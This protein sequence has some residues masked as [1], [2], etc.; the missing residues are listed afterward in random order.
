MS[1][2]L[3]GLRRF[4]SDSTDGQLTLMLWSEEAHYCRAKGGWH[5]RRPSCHPFARP[6]TDPTGGLRPEPSIGLEI[7]IF[8][9]HFPSR[10]ERVRERKPPK[11][12]PSAHCR[13]APHAHRS[14]S[15]TLLRAARA[16]ASTIGVCVCETPRRGG[17]W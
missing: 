8:G 2:V 12:P 10:R 14:G 16:R 3:A 17:R 6:H 9:V 7:H 11:E 13:H 5:A 1:S 15:C 4:G